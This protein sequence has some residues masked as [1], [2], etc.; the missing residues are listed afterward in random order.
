M[1]LSVDDRYLKQELAVF[2]V[3]S[4]SY[5]K[6]ENLGHVIKSEAVPHIIYTFYYILYC[7]YMYRYSIIL[8]I[9]QIVLMNSIVYVHSSTWICTVYCMGILFSG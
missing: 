1:D 3:A 5:L 9:S 2:V 8:R 4:I 6:C 7:I